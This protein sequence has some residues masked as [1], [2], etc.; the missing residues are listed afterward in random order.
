MKTDSQASPQPTPQPQRTNSVRLLFLLAS[1]AVCIG[2]VVAGLLWLRGQRAASAAA[3]SEAAQEQAQAETQTGSPTPSVAPQRGGATASGPRA[4]SALLALQPE[5]TP[6]LRQLV[7]GLVNL[8]T[9]GGPM[10]PE[11]AATWKENFKLLLE[12]GSAA[13]PAI[14]EFLAKNVDYDLGETGRQVLGYA[15]ARQVMIDALAQIG[16]SSA[17]AAMAEVLQTTADPREIAVLGQNLEKLEPGSHQT[18]VLD[19]ARQTLAM[20]AEGNLP[21]RDVAPLFEVFAKFGGV[22]AVSDLVHSAADWNFYSMIAL[23]QLP[24][25]AGIQSLIDIASGQSLSGSGART[26]ALQMLAEM[27]AQSPDARAALTDLVRQ[28]QLSAYDWAT[29]TPS[30]GGN[31]FFFQ[32]SAFSDNANLAN[33]NDIRKTTVAA[34]NQSFLTA[35]LG[36]QTPALV[37]QQQALLDE[38]LAVT[39]DPI[40]V[41]ALQKS[42]AALRQRLAPGNESSAQ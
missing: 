8:D 21:G 2:T 4:P 25:G 23:A 35:P 32:N 41:Q 9:H 7:N 19:A 33:P 37:N 18:E 40:A 10:T 15:S 1:F 5:P 28:N 24:D 27:A 42:K 6:A 34:G 22:A 31:Q 36:A 11:Q 26:P 29:I 12:Q 13:L 20:S 30:L 17:V 16:D 3:Q 14:R 38:L 39:T